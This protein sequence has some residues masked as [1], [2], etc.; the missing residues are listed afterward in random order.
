M[1]YLQKTVSIKEN[2]QCSSEEKPISQQPP[3]PISQIFWAS[4]VRIRISGRLW[5]CNR[6]SSRER[7][8]RMP[9]LRSSS[10]PKGRRRREAP[11]RFARVLVHRAANECDCS[12]TTIL[13][14][15][16]GRKENVL[17]NVLHQLGNEQLGA[18][19]IPI[20]SGS[21]IKARRPLYK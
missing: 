10:K 7:R 14:R 11:F 9:R 2:K 3:T 19:L 16:M 1:K 8:R 21:I 20:P 15:W 17:G 13:V 6:S 12:A 18:R 5:K 4:D